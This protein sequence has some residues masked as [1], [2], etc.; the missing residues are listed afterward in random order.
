MRL[1]IGDSWREFV[2]EHKFE[3]FLSY[4]FDDTWPGF[5]V[6]P[7]SKRQVLDI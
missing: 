4:I 5:L 7:C 6:P 3:R 1:L 2:V